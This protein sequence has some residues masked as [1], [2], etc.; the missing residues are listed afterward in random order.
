MKVVDSHS[1]RAACSDAEWRQRVDLAACYRLADRYRMGKVIW[2]H[3]TA[4]ASARGCTQMLANY[5]PSAKNALV[6]RFFD[7]LGMQRVSSPANTG[8]TNYRLPLPASGLVNRDW[9][10]FIHA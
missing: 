8:V 4:Q 5:V 2:N 1:R 10:E 9:I 7:E 6:E 3:I